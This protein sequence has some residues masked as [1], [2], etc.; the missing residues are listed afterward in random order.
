M[1]Y[2]AIHIILL[3]LCS[4]SRHCSAAI[5]HIEVVHFALIKIIREQ[6]LFMTGVGSEDKIVE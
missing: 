2:L 3:V 5:L 4:C 6:S 1:L